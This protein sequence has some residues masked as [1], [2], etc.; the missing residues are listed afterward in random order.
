[1]PQPSWLEPLFRAIDAKDPD[2]F[3]S[4]LTEQAIFRFGNAEP[5]CGKRAV[6]DAVASFFSAIAGLRHTIR[7]TWTQP[8]AVLLH[9]QVTY[10]RHDGSTLGVPF[11]NVLKLEGDL[12][13][14]Y[15]IFADVSALWS[16]AA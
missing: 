12:V 6:R 9:G 15:L 4:F 13:R 2:A 8:D 16:P 10:T 7:E 5:V 3:A 14:E 1:M 11:A